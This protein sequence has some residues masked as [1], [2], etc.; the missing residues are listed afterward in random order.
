[1]KLGV[2]LISAGDEYL[3]SI[4]RI[5]GFML[6]LCRLSFFSYTARI[7]HNLYRFISLSR[8]QLL[9][10]GLCYNKIYYLLLPVGQKKDFILNCKVAVEITNNK[11]YWTASD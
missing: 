6:V 8:S 1:M 3:N 4:K 2:Y 7:I 9:P 5:S 11:Q 10:A